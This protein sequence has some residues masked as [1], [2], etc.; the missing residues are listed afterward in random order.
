[1]KHARK[2][3]SLLLTAAIALSLLAL[4][5]LTASAAVDITAAFTDTAFKAE[6]HKAIGKTAPAPILDT[7]AADVTVLDMYG[8]SK[9][10]G[11]SKRWIGQGPIKNLNGLEYFTGLTRLDCG[12]N[13]I[14]SLPALPSNLK[15]FRAC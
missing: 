4:T 6:V 1:M 10:D 8:G 9:Y 5:P 3:F 12:G 14:A 13:Q 7:D 2:L 11:A 15:N